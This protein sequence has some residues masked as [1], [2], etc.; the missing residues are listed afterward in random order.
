LV[1]HHLAQFNV[2]SLVTPLNEV[3]NTD[4]VASLDDVN[5]QAEQ[6][7]GFVW[8]AKDDTGNSTA[9]NPY[10][11]PLVVINYS[12]WES[13]QQ[14]RDYTFSGD[15]L[16]MMR[17]RLDWFQRHAEAHHHVLWW[18][19][20]GHIPTVNEAVERLEHLRT[21]GTSPHAFGFRDDVPPPTEN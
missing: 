2:A 19:P 3:E 9:I 10:D 15:H 21:H 4:F 18:I 6:A 1:S 12:V 5:G 8:R 16:T 13:R 11:D 14:L 20:A 17:R 7:L